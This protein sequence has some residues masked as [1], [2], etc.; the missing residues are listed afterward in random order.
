[1]T[2]RSHTVQRIILATTIVAATFAR[3]A[4]AEQYVCETEQS[5]GFSIVQGEW[6]AMPPGTDEA[7]YLINTDTMTISQFGLDGNV[8]EGDDCVLLGSNEP[9]FMR[10]LPEGR[11]AQM[12]IGLKTLRFDSTIHG[13][14]IG[15]R[16]LGAS[17][18]SIGTCA[19]L[20]S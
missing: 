11:L 4:S 10:C 2:N 20:G 7:R 18:I 16:D 9:E 15:D 3:A 1:M 14:A 12:T 6:R 17:L 8:F 13:Y 5:T 19:K